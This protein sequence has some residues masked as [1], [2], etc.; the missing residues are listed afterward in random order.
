MEECDSY[1]TGEELNGFGVAFCM[2]ECGLEH[3]STP[4]PLSAGVKPAAFALPIQAR[5]NENVGSGGTC[6]YDGINSCAAMVDDHFERL[7]TPTGLLYE[8]IPRQDAN[9]LLA[10]DSFWQ[11]HYAQSIS[12]ERAVALQT[13]IVNLFSDLLL[14]I[15]SRLPSD[16]YNSVKGLRVL[17][18]S[19]DVRI[20]QNCLVGIH[21]HISKSHGDMLCFL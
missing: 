11:D 6:W 9:H 12:T 1:I 17:A 19:L 18:N 14:E 20:R 13:E 3:L 16:G 4:F 15:S 7:A 2:L 8:L 21:G 5:V 10:R